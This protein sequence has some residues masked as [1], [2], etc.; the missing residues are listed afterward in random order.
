R[1]GYRHEHEL[2]FFPESAARPGRARRIAALLKP[3]AHRLALLARTF[4]AT[5]ARSLARGTRGA[6]AG[7]CCGSSATDGKSYWHDPVDAGV[8]GRRAAGSGN[9]YGRAGTCH[10]E[11][12][13]RTILD[14]GGA[15]HPVA[16]G[17]HLYGHVAGAGAAAGFAVF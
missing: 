13:R 16:P 15:R 4:A 17:G 10:A 5:P 2:A 1:K 11:R 9:L 7:E 6:A 3:A 8:S 14:R 12:D